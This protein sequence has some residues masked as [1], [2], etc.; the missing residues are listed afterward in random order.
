MTDYQYIIKC[1]CR[2][3]LV[4]LASLMTYVVV[5]P[6]YNF[7]HWVPHH[8][9]KRIGLSYK[10]VLYFEQH[11][12]ILLHLFGAF[13]LTLLLYC[14]AFFKNRLSV[15]IIILLLVLSTEIVQL[16]IGRGFDLIDL[17]LGVAGSMFA[18]LLINRQSSQ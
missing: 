13:I 4:T 16:I 1:F 5:Q 10:A 3:A 7:A 14:S 9:L 17:T 6:E 18:L 12:D 8:F 11:A 15:V 2:F